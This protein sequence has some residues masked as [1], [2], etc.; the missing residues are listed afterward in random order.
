MIP[1][2]VWLCVCRAI[3]SE[4]TAQMIERGRAGDPSAAS[5]RRKM[6]IKLRHA[7]QTLT[8]ASGDHSA[9]Y[10][11]L[12]RLFARSAKLVSPA[13]AVMVLAAAYAAYSWLP[14]D[15]ALQWTALALSALVLRYFLGWTCLRRSNPEKS[16]GWWR[17]WFVSGEAYSGVTWA[18]LLFT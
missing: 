8:S 2:G 14:L 13:F 1:R 4:I 3:M 7:R 12:V 17:L 16:A 11:S 10:D 15:R 6:N 18:A 5:R 9:P